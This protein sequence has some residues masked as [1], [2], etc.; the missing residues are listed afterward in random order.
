MKI[1]VLVL[2]AAVVI[3]G[4]VGGELIGGAF[5]IT[6]AVVGGVGTFAVLMGL[7]AFFSK[8]DDKKKAA[9]LPP[10]MRG[11]FDRMFKGQSG[12]DVVMKAVTNLI[13]QDRAEIAAGRI[14]ERRLIPHHAIKR[15][16]IVEAFTRD[17]K[18]LS[19]GMQDLNR[20]DFEQKIG[21]IKQ[22]HQDDLDRMIE[23][24][25]QQRTDLADIEEK[26]RERN[27]MYGFLP[28]LFI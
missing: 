10:E 17:F 24:M 3:G 26:V 4:F 15:D 16:V 25:R 23:T 18:R 5:S 21:G 20:A 11:V 7:G 19:Q 13:E 6:G 8:Q 27:Q 22:M 12:N 14:P 9:N 28:R 1:F 2:A